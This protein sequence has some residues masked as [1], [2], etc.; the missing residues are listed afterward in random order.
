MIAVTQRLKNPL[1]PG[2]LYL[3]NTYAA[4][5]PKIKCP[6]V[7]TNVVNTVLKMYLVKGT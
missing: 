3:A 5:D 6:T 1:L 7:P 4:I 2:K